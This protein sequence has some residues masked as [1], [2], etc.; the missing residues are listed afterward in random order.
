MIIAM[1]CWTAFIGLVAWKK[2]WFDFSSSL[3]NKQKEEEEVLT[4]LVILL[5]VFFLYFLSQFFFTILGKYLLFGV[6]P[7]EKWLPIFMI[8][9]VGSFVIWFSY[10]SP[11]FY[12]FSVWR[13]GKSL[14][15]QG[16][17][18]FKGVLFFCL[19]YPVV[20]FI[21]ISIGYLRETFISSEEMNQV[22]VNLVKQN[23]ESP[24]MVFFTIVAVSFITPIVEE[25]LFRGYLQSYL[26]FLC[27]T[28]VAILATSA[29]FS[30]LHFSIE[31]S[32]SNLELLCSLFVL[33]CFMGVL[34]EKDKSL[35]GP[36]GLH[37][38]FNLFNVCMIYAST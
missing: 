14:W 6:G 32:W 25:V 21:G 4:S 2:G 9:G 29:L 30:F 35:W 20:M 5:Q 15:E 10:L 1:F 22:A 27:G 19:S 34:Y 26:K 36:I 17:S 37:A 7:L 12:N 38:F 11:S 18:F 8:F 23:M 33:S 31:Q 28:R 24:L 13:Q 16:R 3:G